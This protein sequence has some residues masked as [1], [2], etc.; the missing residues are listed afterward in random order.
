MRKIL[1]ATTAL[2]GVAL[3]GTAQAA[4]TSPISLNV[5][6]Y[7]DFIAATQHGGANTRGSESI[8]NDFEN[9]FKISF[10]ALGKASN[11][12]E[13]GANI[14]L[15]NGAEVG[16]VSGGVATPWSG[17]TNGVVVNSAYV[18]L[19]GAFGKVL[20]GDEHGASDL[21]VYA[22]TVGEGQIDGRYTD[23]VSSANIAAPMIRPSGTDNTEHSTKVT[24]YTPKVGNDTNKVQL[25]VSFAPSLYDYGQSGILGQ[26]N[27]AATAQGVTTNGN[28]PY[29]DVIEADLQ[30]TGNF[31]PVDV[32]VS[33]QW[34][35]GG[36]G[37]ANLNTTA[38]GSGLST[39]QVGGAHSFNAWGLGTQVA[40][41]GV[42]LGGGYNRLGNYN[43]VEGQ[44]RTQDSYNIG[45]KYEFDKVGVAA[46]LIHGKGY[47]NLLT[48]GVGGGVA[49]SATNYVKKFNAA[50]AGATYTW[51]PGLTS[52][53]D[54]VIYGQERDA[55]AAADQ[56]KQGGYTVLVSQRLA[57]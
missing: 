30:Y 38:L 24:Y 32:T 19:S 39:T 45:A 51:F 48:G 20:F 22:P 41:N 14:S 8:N 53:L 49:T 36:Q 15:W 57:F 29:R 11:G 7:N 25:G 17:G 28:S 31:K 21:F 33:A 9:E 54:G 46:S 34:T 37:H 12:V 40:F 56:T 18:W 42:T 55:A 52:N 50:G 16:N 2:F 6:G 43:T 44:N 23:F 4:P 5:G 3:V 10:D 47:D 1:L 27:A 35:H 13:Y 26:T